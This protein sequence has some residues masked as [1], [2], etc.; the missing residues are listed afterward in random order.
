M[1]SPPANCRAIS[2]HDRANQQ[3]RHQLGGSKVLSKALIIIALKTFHH[4]SL[5]FTSRTSRKRY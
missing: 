1:L 3:I 5:S 4:G 2:K